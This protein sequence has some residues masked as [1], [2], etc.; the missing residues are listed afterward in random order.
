MELGLKNKVAIVTGAG[1]QIGFGKGIALAL[2]REGCDIVIADINLEGSRQT[3]AGIIALKRQAIAVK[4]DVRKLSD[5]EAMAKAALDKFGKIDI[6]V[7]NAGTSARPRPF[8]EMT[9]ADWDIDINVNLRGVLNCTRAVLPHMVSRKYGKVIN[10][11]SGVGVTGMPAEAVY[12]ASKAGIIAFTK[13]M[14][15]AMISQGIYFNNVAPGIGDTG[16]LV[17]SGVPREFLAQALKSVPLGRA[18]TPQDIGTVIAFLASDVS[19]DIVGQT[20]SVDG[21]TLML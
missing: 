4:T 3:A 14:A 8:L 17:A 20:F 10:I 1:S 12:A 21:G 7:N 19:G 16:L 13:S 11:S 9:E 2:A 5:A 18:T 15:K 6:L